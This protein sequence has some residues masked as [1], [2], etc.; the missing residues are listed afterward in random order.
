MQL[1]AEEHFSGLAGLPKADD[2]GFGSRGN[3]FDAVIRG[4]TQ[5]WN[6]V[7]KPTVAL[8]PD[9]I[10]ALIASESGFNTNSGIK[11]R[12]KSAKGLMQLT[13]QTTESL[14]NEHGELKDHFVNIPK[15]DLGDPNLNIAGGIRWLFIKLETASSKLGRAATWV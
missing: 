8:D 15:A 2:L 6:E 13:S 7:L 12:R 3:A 11:R 9:L 1:I 10:K 14:R 5:Y 4:W